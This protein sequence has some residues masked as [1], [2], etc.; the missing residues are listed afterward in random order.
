MS[1]SLSAIFPI[2]GLCAMA[3]N[4]KFAH[5]IKSKEKKEWFYVYFSTLSIAAF[6]FLWLMSCANG[7]G[8]VPLGLVMVATFVAGCTAA[9]PYYLLANLFAIEYGGKDSSATLVSI[10]EVVA[11]LTKS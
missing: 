10:Y 4:F 6:G 5:N 11:F 7:A 9:P 3:T 1:V 8:N 2:G